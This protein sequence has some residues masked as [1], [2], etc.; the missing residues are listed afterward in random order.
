[1]IRHINK[2]NM[3]LSVALGIFIAAQGVLFS[4]QN[5]VVQ[6]KCSSYTVDEGVGVAIVNVER[7][8]D[9]NDEV[10]V[11]WIMTGGTAGGGDF[12]DGSDSLQFFPGETTKDI[13]IGI[14]DDVLVEV[15]ETVVL[16]LRVTYPQD[17]GVGNV[18]E[19]LIRDNEIAPALTR[20]KPHLTGS[21]FLSDTAY[22][23]GR[24]VVVGGGG[25]LTSM[26]GGDW[27]TNW[28]QQE[29]GTNAECGSFL[30]PDR[31]AYGNGIFVA[32]QSSYPAPCALCC[33]RRVGL[34]VNGADWLVHEGPLARELIFGNGVFVAAD[35]NGIL[36]SENGIDWVQSNLLG[37]GNGIQLAFGNGIFVGVLC[38]GIWVSRDGSIWT[39]VGGDLSVCLL[40]VAYGN[41]TFVAV[42]GVGPEGTILTSRDGMAW[43]Q[44]RQQNRR[45][46]SKVSYGGGFFLVSSRLP[47]FTAVSSDGVTWTELNTIGEQ[48]VELL[49]GP[50]P[51]GSFLLALS[52]DSRRVL[53]SDPVV[54]L[55]M[56]WKGSPEL[57]IDGPLGSTCRIE[58]APSLEAT[59]QW[60]SLGTVTL[61]NTIF[62]WQGD[63]CAAN[64]FYRAV[65]LP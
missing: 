26:D 59:R 15:D 51:E 23:N 6:F 4:Q 49:N 44:R 53:R 2:R 43:I 61:S 62:S 39:Q 60:T 37:E 52:S 57:I 19:L 21:Q 54:R 10:E 8:G 1:M 55:D 11:T 64:Q 41:G 65:L 17:V 7:V 45:Y 12:S 16:G 27:T 56:K 47:D 29:L 46:L 63:L 13:L 42:G 38:P 32:A 22:G 36:T 30:H 24:Y 48:P 33:G 31:I 25:I 58:A 14:V 28:T 50:K 3:K 18:A 9:T 20:W 5:T 40:D 35:Y 34:S